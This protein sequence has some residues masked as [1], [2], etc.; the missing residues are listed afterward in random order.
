MHQDYFVYLNKYYPNFGFNILVLIF[1]INL[2]MLL[3]M[4]DITVAAVAL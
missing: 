4:C 1:F 2:L 3:S